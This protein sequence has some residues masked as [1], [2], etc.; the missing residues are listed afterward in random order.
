MIDAK[1]IFVSPYSQFCLHVEP[2]IA[3]HFFFV[4]RGIK[5]TLDCF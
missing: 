3:A 5:E 2:V 4:I 1:L